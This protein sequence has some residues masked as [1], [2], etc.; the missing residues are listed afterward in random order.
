MFDYEFRVCA[1]LNGDFDRASKLVLN[2][3]LKDEDLFALDLSQRLPVFEQVED[4]TYWETTLECVNCDSLDFITETFITHG[5][6]EVLGEI[7]VTLAD[8]CQ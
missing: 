5:N 3:F 2:L 8:V 1:I 4:L 7:V 6:E